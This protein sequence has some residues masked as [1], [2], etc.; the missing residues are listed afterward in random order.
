MKGVLA[1]F[2]IH[3]AISPHID[4]QASD[5]TSRSARQPCPVKFAALQ[6]ILEPSVLQAQEDTQNR[7]QCHDISARHPARPGIA[8]K[9]QC[10]RPA[11]V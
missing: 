3:L 4:D 8:E 9:G 11:C 7:S 10:D 6:K 1:L 5:E 2:D